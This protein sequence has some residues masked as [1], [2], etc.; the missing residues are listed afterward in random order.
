MTSG[1]MVSVEYCAILRPAHV[2]PESLDF[3][4]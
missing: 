4:R 2:I 1:E 3:P